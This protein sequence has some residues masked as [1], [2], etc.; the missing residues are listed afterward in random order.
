MPRLQRVGLI[1]HHGFERWNSFKKLILPV[2][3]EADVQPDSRLLRQQMF[4]F[5]QHLQSFCPLLATHVDDAEIR[6]RSA[7]LRIQSQHLAEVAFR[8]V[9]PALVQRVLPRSKKLCGI[10]RRSRRGDWRAISR[11]GRRSRR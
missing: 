8:F 6:V 2:I 1:A 10:C 5:A 4:R 7:G 3:G 11:L 9:Q